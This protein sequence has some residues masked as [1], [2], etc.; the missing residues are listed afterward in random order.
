[1]FYM[2]MFIS[3]FDHKITRQ[4]VIIF[5]FFWGGGEG[6]ANSRFCWRDDQDHH[7][8]QGIFTGFVVLRSS[9]SC[10]SLNRKSNML[11]FNADKI[12][13][14]YRRIEGLCSPTASSLVPFLLQRIFTARCTYSAIS[15]LLLPLVVRP[16]VR[17]SVAARDILLT[18]VNF[19]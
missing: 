5:F 10:M 13:Q 15:A 9:N 2:G 16:S 19:K 7:P 18:K 8:D 4:V 1:M 12:K 6:V 14:S 3:L 17:L 11:H